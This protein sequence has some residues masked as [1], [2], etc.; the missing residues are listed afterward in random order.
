MSSNKPSLQFAQLFRSVSVTR[1]AYPL[2]VVVVFGMII[3]S[4]FFSFRFFL[5]MVGRITALPPMERTQGVTFRLD[6]YRAVAPFFRLVPLAQEVSREGRATIVVALQNKQ[7]RSDPLSLAQLILKEDGWNV[8]LLPEEERAGAPSLEQ[9]TTVAT[10]ATRAKDADAL[11]KL[12][13]KNGFVVRSATLPEAEE[14]DIVITLGA[15]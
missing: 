13:A 4:A 7:L 3:L 11:M 12:L 1:I 14:H 6:A 2:G 9:L 8:T 5:V 15:Y 10:K